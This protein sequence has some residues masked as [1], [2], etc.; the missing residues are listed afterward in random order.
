MELTQAGRAFL[1]VARSMLRQY[2]SAFEVTRR[3]AR[4]QTG[5]LNVGATPTSAFHPIVP[6]AIRSFR[7][8]FPEDNLTL[9]ERLPA[10]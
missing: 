1:E 8:E 6:A 4:G 7:D 9:E 3:A 5:R 2:E 10:K